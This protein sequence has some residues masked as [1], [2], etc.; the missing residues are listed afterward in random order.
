MAT[1]PEQLLEAREAYHALQIGKATAS[2]RDA[3]GEEV[4]YSRA[5]IGRLAAYIRELEALSGG[6]RLRLSVKF[7]TS[8]GL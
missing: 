6:Q 8:K 2:V 1:L 5:D 7:Q 4:T 3:N